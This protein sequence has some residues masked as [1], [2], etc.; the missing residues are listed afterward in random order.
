MDIEKG[1]KKWF[2][3]EYPNDRKLLDKKRI[4]SWILTK[5][6]GFT[7]GSEYGYKEGRI[8]ELKEFMTFI[9]NTD[10]DNIYRLMYWKIK[11]F[12]NTELEK[13]NK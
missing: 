5:E 9:D 12:I 11:E 8:E 13:V 7:G 6:H 2:T 4:P 1:F 10:L 3:N